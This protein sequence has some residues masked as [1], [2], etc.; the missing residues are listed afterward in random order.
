V[1]ADEEIHMAPTDADWDLP[2]Q[3]QHMRV[4]EVT[5]RQSGVVLYHAEMSDHAP[6]PMGKPRVDPDGIDAPIQPSGPTCNAELP[7]KIHVE[8]PSLE[9]D[10]Q[11]RYDTVTW[12]PPLPQNIFTQTAP[13]GMPTTPVSCQDP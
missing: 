11:F 4:L 10:V 1:G 13:Q 5:V 6:A 8:V 2:W 7:R 12:N 3:Q 9:E